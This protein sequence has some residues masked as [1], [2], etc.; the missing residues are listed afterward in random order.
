[1]KNIWAL[2]LAVV[3]GIAYAF[4]G[5]ILKKAALEFNTQGGWLAAVGRAVTSKYLIIS[6]LCSACGYGLYFLIIRKAE[7]ITTTLIIQGIL[8]AA[9]MVFASLL[10]K[11]TITPAKIVATLLITVGIAVLVAVK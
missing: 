10:F 9:T 8:F 2:A 6:L 4:G 7:V 11:E 3:S 5:T 1:M